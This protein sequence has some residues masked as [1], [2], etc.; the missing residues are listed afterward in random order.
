MKRLEGFG[1]LALAVS[2][3][4]FLVAS[5]SSKEVGTYSVGAGDTGGT[6]SLQPNRTEPPRN[7]LS[8]DDVAREAGM[9]TRPLDKLPLS[10]KTNYQAGKMSQSTVTTQAEDRVNIFGAVTNDNGANLCAMVL[11]NGVYM[12]T[13]GASLG[14]YSLDVP[15]DANN[16]ITLFGFAAGHFP[17]ETTVNASGGR[18]DIMVNVALPAPTPTPTPTPNSNVSFTITDACIDG[19]YIEYRFFDQTNNLWWPSVSK[20]YTTTYLNTPYRSNLSC[21]TGANICYGGSTGNNYWG[22]AVDNSESCT[23]CC[24]TCVEGASMSR[25]LTCG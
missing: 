21:K 8:P 22:V 1:Q 5:A 18:Q 24:I 20:V 12:F 17:F 9:N 14:T 13:C 16:Q 4:I 3:L 19:F 11:A 7:A 25:T 15:L 23:D 6:Y 10:E 2:A